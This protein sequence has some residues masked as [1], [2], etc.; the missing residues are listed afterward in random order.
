MGLRISTFTNMN[1]EYRTHYD[2]K[3]LFTFTSSQRFLW[4]YLHPDTTMHRRCRQLASSNIANFNFQHRIH[5]RTTLKKPYKDVSGMKPSILSPALLGCTEECCSLR[6][7][8]GISLSASDD[9][10][11]SLR[12]L[13]DP[14]SIIGRSSSISISSTRKSG[15]F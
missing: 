1:S 9:D 6:W 4:P 14:F 5:S 7:V 10:S 3:E 11:D 2:A 15:L 8:E 12:G 13:G